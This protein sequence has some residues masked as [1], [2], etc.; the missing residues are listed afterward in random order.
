MGEQWLCLRDEQVKVR[1]DGKEAGG[2][3]L[4]EKLF[5]FQYECLIVKVTDSVIAWPFVHA[6][7]PTGPTVQ[8]E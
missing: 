4:R 7:V 2:Q 3:G 6:P 1:A 5:S 8:P